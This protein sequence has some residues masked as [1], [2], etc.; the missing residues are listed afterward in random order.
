MNAGH[1]TGS[2]GESWGILT[3]GKSGSSKDILKSWKCS[4]RWSKFALQKQSC[5]TKPT[6]QKQRVEDITLHIASLQQAERSQASAWQLSVLTF[7]SSS[8]FHTEDSHSVTDLSQVAFSNPFVFHMSSFGPCPTPIFLEV[9]CWEPDTK[10]QLKL[11]WCQVEHSNF[12]CVLHKALLQ[13]CLHMTFAF[14]CG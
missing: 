9:W 3:W 6:K 2:W 13:V 14:S 11:H 10:L 4:N 1:K 8:Y 7:P 5:C 12:F